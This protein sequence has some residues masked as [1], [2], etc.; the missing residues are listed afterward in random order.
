MIE[1]ILLD[2]IISIQVEKVRRLL[3][4]SQRF[5]PVLTHFQCHSCTD[6]INAFFDQRRNALEQ[7]RTLG[8]RCCAPSWKGGS[9]RGHGVVHIID[10][11]EREMTE[12]APLIDRA[13]P[14]IVLRGDT[15]LTIN[16]ERMGRA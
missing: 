3:H 13:A 15:V 11:G 1:T 12:D 7:A 5:H 9:S 4:L 8:H 2:K 6:L 14:S 16:V 10:R